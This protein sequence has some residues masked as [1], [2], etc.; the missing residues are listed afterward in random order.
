MG[1]LKYTAIR[2]KAGEMNE[3]TEQ[4]NNG[5]AVTESNSNIAMS[6]GRTN[7]CY[8]ECLHVPPVDLVKELR[9]QLDPQG[10]AE[11]LPQYHL[12]S[13]TALTHPVKITKYCEL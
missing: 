13:S 1:P 8:F 10:T 5:I 6:N 3:S 11:S 2:S 12:L 7:G 9:I 4:R